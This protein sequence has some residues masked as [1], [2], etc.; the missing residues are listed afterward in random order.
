ME[1][2]QFKGEANG[3]RFFYVADWQTEYPREWVAYVICP[4]D[5]GRDPREHY[6]IKVTGP[7]VFLPLT[8]PD[9]IANQISGLLNEFLE[10]NPE[11]R[12]LSR[13]EAWV[14]ETLSQRS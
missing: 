5:V 8:T 4:E 9:E 2:R 6:C 13:A 11:V 14:G 1:I 12:D 7:T 3:R 10:R